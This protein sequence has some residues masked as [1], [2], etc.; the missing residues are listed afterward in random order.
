MIWFRVVTFC[1]AIILLSNGWCLQTTHNETVFYSV[2][3]HGTSV[4]FLVSCTFLL[5]SSAR[6]TYLR[7]SK[8][9]LWIFL[10]FSKFTNLTEFSCYSKILKLTQLTF[11]I[12]FSKWDFRLHYIV[13]ADS[14]IIILI[15]YTTF[16]VGEAHERREYKNAVDKHFFRGGVVYSGNA[17]LNLK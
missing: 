6:I 7:E 15:Y 13:Y 12:V 14:W 8:E 9:A 10:H 4:F 3:P 17:K 5:F 1:A 11:K 2:D 16:E